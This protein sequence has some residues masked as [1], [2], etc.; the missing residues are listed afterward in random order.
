VTFLGFAIIFHHKPYFVDYSWGHLYLAF[1]CIVLPFFLG[2]LAYYRK[3][4]RG[5]V[6]DGVALRV[7]TVV[8]AV[9]FFVLAMIEGVMQSLRI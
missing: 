9:T 4:K 8:L 3:S 6:P 2:A 7:A 1:T 5:S